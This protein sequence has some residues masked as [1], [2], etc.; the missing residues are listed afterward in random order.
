[1]SHELS[2]V[3]KSSL[4]AGFLPIV[5]L[6]L[7]LIAW[8][9]RAEAQVSNFETAAGAISGTVLLQANNR[10]ASQ[11]LV[12]LKS[13]SA[14]ISRR[15]LTDVEGH[16]AVRRLPPSTYEITVEEPGYEPAHTSA[17]LKG[18]STELVLYLSPSKSVGIRRSDAV[19]SVRELKIPSKALSEFRKG[20]DRLEKNDPAGS[21][22]HFARAAQD[23]PDFYEAY[24]HMGVAKIRLGREDEAMQAFQTAIDLSGGH[25]AWAELGL[26][27]LLCQEGKAGE[28]ERVIRRGLE[29]DEGSPEGYVILGSALLQL[30]RPDEAEKSLSEALLRNPNFA[31]AYLVRSDIY[32]LKGEYRAQLE[33]LDVY[34]KLEPNGPAS[35]RVRRGREAAL[36]ILANSQPQE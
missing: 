31:D 1:M 21:L 4:R 11:V 17:E 29:G 13:V 3:E 19:V 23:Y 34:L 14:G 20:L 18:S 36:K 22:S 15:V 8:N 33:D 16:F 30:N 35:E 7:A 26:G 10:P 32:A 12:N 24:Y 28:A 6:N 27:Y 2:K 5:F 25:Y 9:V